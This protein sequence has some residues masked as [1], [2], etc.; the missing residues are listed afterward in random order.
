MVAVV[1]GISRRKLRSP[2]RRR[3]SSTHASATTASNHP[4]RPVVADHC[5][6]IVAQ[7]ARVVPAGRTC[8]HYEY[9]FA[10][11]QEERQ[12]KEV[13]LWKA[14]LL[15]V[16][17]LSLAVVRQEPC[18][19]G[20]GIQ[21]SRRGCTHYEYTPI[22]AAEH[23]VADGGAFDRVYEQPENDSSWSSPFAEA[24]TQRRRTETGPG[25][26][27]PLLSQGIIDAHFCHNG[28]QSPAAA[29]SSLIAAP[30]SSLIAAAL[31]SLIAAPLSSLKKP[32]S[33]R[34]GGLVL[35]MSTASLTARKNDRTQRRSCG[36]RLCCW[37]PCCRWPL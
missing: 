23:D 10:H 27:T 5:A 20:L 34:R 25:E 35:I 21:V 33:S 22:T 14:A 37:W 4:L 28:Q 30:L 36:K 26:A 3:E 1:R 32:A 31:S 24:K 13:L 12:N 11:S 29:L 18:R 2:S 7:E 9:S 16:A 15:L 19:K 8:T 6:P 17:L